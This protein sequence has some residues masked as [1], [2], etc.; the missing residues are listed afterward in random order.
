ML[1]HITVP[2]PPPPHDRPET[3]L[4]H[5]SPH[6][7][8]C[9]GQPCSCEHHHVVRPPIVP[10]T[11]GEPHRGQTPPGVRAGSSDRTCT[12]PPAM[13]VSTTLCNARYSRS[14][15]VRDNSSTG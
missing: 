7:I 10:R 9:G 5:G 4:Q 13:A 8:T 14:I 1:T 6:T 3:L 2:A 11:M 12:P 15:S